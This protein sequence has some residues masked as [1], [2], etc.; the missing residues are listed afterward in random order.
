[1]TI[2]VT[3]ARLRGAVEAGLG[4]IVVDC[5]YGEGSPQARAWL[6]GYVF[7]LAEHVSAKPQE[8]APSVA[9]HVTR[10]S[11]RWLWVERHFVELAWPT[12][13]V[14]AELAR[15]L[16]RSPLSVRVAACR[17]GL[18]NRPGSRRMKTKAAAEMSA[19]A[20]AVS[21]KPQG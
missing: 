10:D 15:R 7:G 3:M 16:S 19:D 17:L 18:G 2:E 1:M 14:I 9:L 5:P 13:L 20:A 12:G 6:D 8:P 21:I 11:A 4:A